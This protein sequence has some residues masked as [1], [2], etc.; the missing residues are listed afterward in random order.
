MDKQEL[1][2]KTIKAISLLLVPFLFVECASR[3]SVITNSAET[4]NEVHF[5]VVADT[6]ISHDTVI[7]LQHSD[8]RIMQRIAEVEVQIPQAE[9][10]RKTGDTISVLETPFYVST[11]KWSGGELTHTLKSK[12]GATIKA[13]TIVTDTAQMVRADAKCSSN[14]KVVRRENNADSITNSKCRTVSE[15]PGKR[16]NANHHGF[17][18]VAGIVILFFALRAGYC[19]LKRK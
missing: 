7:I 16:A 2:M 5:Q 13:K 4:K 14:S 18:I 6:A 19:K 17:W 8:T 12:P 9:K 1:Q 15:R 10:E 3:R 11:A